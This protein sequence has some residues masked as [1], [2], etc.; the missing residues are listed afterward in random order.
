MNE[1]HE[2]SDAELAQVEGGI[3]PVLIL[4]FGLGL[5]VGAFCESIES[6]N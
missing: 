6:V 5:F 2:L 3:V 4:G 1:M